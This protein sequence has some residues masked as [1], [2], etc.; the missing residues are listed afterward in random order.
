MEAYKNIC[1]LVAEFNYLFGVIDYK[2]PN[3]EQVMVDK[4]DSK[5]P[6]FNLTQI[7]LRHSLINE[8][9]KELQQA[10]IDIDE[11]EIIDALCDILYVVAGAKVYFNLPII[12]IKDHYTQCSL[13]QMTH[14]NILNIKNLISSNEQIK[15]IFEKILVKNEILDNLTEL[16]VNDKKLNFHNLLI[17]DFIDIY[18]KNLDDIVVNVF[19]ISK[20]LNINIIYYFNIVHNSNMSKICT[21]EED[22]INTIEWYKKNELTSDNKPRY[23]AIYKK[24][25]YNKKDY[26]VVCDIDTKKILKSI[27]YTEAKFT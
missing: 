18:N 15:K 27:K 11:I 2:Y 22:A 12:D 14:L 3:N 4:F 17:K 20:L 1:N 5:S 7:K 21:N 26:F 23:K 10:L 16:F 19:K 25:N 8:E 9:I 24:I 6:L 13:E